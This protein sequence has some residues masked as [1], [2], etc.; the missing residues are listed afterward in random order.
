MARMRAF[1]RFFALA[2]LLTPVVVLNVRIG[3]QRSVSAL[4]SLLDLS[5][6]VESYYFRGTVQEEG[7]DDCA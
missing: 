5:A 7:H 3:V 6:P 1:M 4:S 2:V